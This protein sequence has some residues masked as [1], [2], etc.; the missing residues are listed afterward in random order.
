MPN[1]T[2]RSAQR[3]KSSAKRSHLLAQRRRTSRARAF[4]N[5]LSTMLYSCVFTI[6]RTQSTVPILV[7]HFKIDTS[8]ICRLKYLKVTYSSPASSGICFTYT[9]ESHTSS[10]DAVNRSPALMFSPLPRKHTLWCPRST[11]YA[12]FSDTSPISEISVYDPSGVRAQI[13]THF[14][15]TVCIEF[16]N[17]QPQIINIDPK[18]LALSPIELTPSTSCAPTPTMSQPSSHPDLPSDHPMATDRSSPFEHL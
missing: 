10:D 17:A 16:R 9:I 2:L 15:F 14:V 3:K 1:P 6:S 7:S 18:N 5:R 12:Y 11:D 8:R 4:R 13:P